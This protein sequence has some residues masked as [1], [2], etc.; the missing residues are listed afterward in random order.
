MRWFWTRRKSHRLDLRLESTPLSLER[1]LWS[2]RRYLPNR[3]NSKLPLLH[4]QSSH[5]HSTLLSPPLDPLLPRQATTPIPA[6]EPRVR[7]RSLVALYK[8]P[9]G[10]RISSHKQPPNSVAMSERSSTPCS[11][12]SSGIPRRVS[13]SRNCGGSWPRIRRTDSRCSDR[14]VE[15]RSRRSRRWSEN[16]G[17]DARFAIVLT[18]RVV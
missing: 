14:R 16:I 8:R 13:R 11:T 6:A 2:Q 10:P 3:R 5:P 4:L 7:S 15:R 18:R 9:S 17:P 1:R 12:Y